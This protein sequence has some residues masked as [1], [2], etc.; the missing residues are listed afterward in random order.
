MKDQICEK[1]SLLHCTTSGHII[2]SYLR[3]SR[4]RDVSPF[5]APRE[6]REGECVLSHSPS[7]VSLGAWN[8]LRDVEETKVFTSR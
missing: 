4:S 8:R 3:D 1:S 7:R 5:Q 6:M 2:V